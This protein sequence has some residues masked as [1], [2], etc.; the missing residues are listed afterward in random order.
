[1]RADEVCYVGDD[2]I[3]LP[4][5]RLCGLAVAVKNSREEVIRESHY[6]TPNEGGKGAVRD[7]IE[8]VLREQGLLE[9][10]IDDYIHARSSEAATKVQ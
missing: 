5:M 6:V 2:V 9:R 3:D 8:Y 10:V 1:L 4:V 7:A